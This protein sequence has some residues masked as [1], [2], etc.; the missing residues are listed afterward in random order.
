MHNN[1]EAEVHYIPPRDEYEEF[2]TE[3]EQHR[4]ENIP[5]DLFRKLNSNDN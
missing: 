1:Q 5:F 4:K 3:L 2:E